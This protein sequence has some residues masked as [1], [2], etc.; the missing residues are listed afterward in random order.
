MQRSFGRRDRSVWKGVVA[1][2]VGGVV[3]SWVMNQFQAALPKPSQQG[4]NEDATM[5]A[6][7]AIS[8]TLA[9]TR[10]GAVNEVRRFRRE[11]IQPRRR[12]GS[13]GHGEDVA[14]VRPSNR[15]WCA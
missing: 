1:G 2:M 5:K 6:A 9:A 10:G 13:E 14:S 12:G 4:E 7:E 11:R 8:E 15:R 3:A